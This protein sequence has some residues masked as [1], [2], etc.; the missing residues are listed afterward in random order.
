LVTCGGEARRRVGGGGAPAAAAAGGPAGTRSAHLEVALAERV[1]DGLVVVGEDDLVRCVVEQLVLRL[2]LLELVLE[3][4]E[5]PVQSPE[6]I[7][8]VLV[9]EAD[10]DVVL[11]LL[12]RHLRCGGRWRRW[13]KSAARRSRNFTNDFFFRRVTSS[14]A[15]STSSASPDGLTP[16]ARRVPRSLV[17]LVAR[18]RLAQR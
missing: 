10:L 3:V 17:H 6:R 11:A 4:V 7:D 1:A 14:T 9:L 12:R 18:R 8:R 5:P 16:C 13:R 15:S 2:L